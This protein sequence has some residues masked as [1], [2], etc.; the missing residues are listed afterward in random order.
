MMDRRSFF[1]AAVT[2]PIAIAA[3]PA[4]GIACEFSRVSCVA[5]DPGERAYGIL[6]ARGLRPTV[7]LNGVEQGLAETADVAL[8]LVTRAVDAGGGGIAFNNATG[9][10]LR[11]TVYGRVEITVA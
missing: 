10:V 7:W 11:E 6:C 8:G 1:R 9:E 2:A 4:S 3:A 5:G